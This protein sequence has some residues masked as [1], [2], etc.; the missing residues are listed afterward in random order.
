MPGNANAATQQM[1]FNGGTY[2]LTGNNLSPSSY[3]TVNGFKGNLATLTNTSAVYQVPPQVAANTQ[4]TFSLQNA[5]RLS[6]NKF[7]QIS[8]TTSASNV[9]SAFDGLTNTFYGSNNTDCYLGVD[10]GNGQAVS[11]HRIRLFPNI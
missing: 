6:N 11:V 7:T 3:I 10:A 5:V 1:S 2:T 8:D 9:S 4:S